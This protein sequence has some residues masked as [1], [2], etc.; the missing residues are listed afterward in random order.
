MITLIK[1]GT[2]ALIYPCRNDLQFQQNIQQLTG[3]SGMTNFS[4]PL[5]KL[6]DTIVKES[7]KELL[8]V[9]LTDGWNQD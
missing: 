4:I 5:N 1:F 9:F 6:K 3:S 2:D 8:V 7:I